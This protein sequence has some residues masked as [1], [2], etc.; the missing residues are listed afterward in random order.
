M[1]VHTE[2][3]IYARGIDG[4]LNLVDVANIFVGG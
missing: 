3:D 2:F 1:S 4:L